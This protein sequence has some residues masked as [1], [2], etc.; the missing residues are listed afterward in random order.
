MPTKGIIESGQ[1][2]SQP[3]VMVM[4]GGLARAN[5][6]LITTRWAGFKFIMVPIGAKL[7]G[8]IPPSAFA[9]VFAMIWGSYMAADGLSEIATPAR[10][11]LRA[12][13]FRTRRLC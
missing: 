6:L 1:S 2:I 5:C 11:H 10:P 3:S 9:A 7:A 12:E 8:I 13:S 4:D